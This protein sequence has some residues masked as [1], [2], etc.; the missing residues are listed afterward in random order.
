MTRSRTAVVCCQRDLAVGGLKPVAARGL[1]VEIGRELGAI[2]A[3]RLNLR[4]ELVLAM[5][6]LTPA[7]GCGLEGIERRG[8]AAGGCVDCA[9]VAHDDLPAPRGRRIRIG[10]YWPQQGVAEETYGV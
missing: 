3:E 9:R 10:K 2:G 7:L 8:Q 1:R 6:G 5:I 4:G